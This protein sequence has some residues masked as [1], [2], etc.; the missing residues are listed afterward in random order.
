MVV[1]VADASVQSLVEVSLVLPRE[2]ASAA[3]HVAEADVKAR[4]GYIHYKGVARVKLP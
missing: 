1:F 3:L 4:V 2:V